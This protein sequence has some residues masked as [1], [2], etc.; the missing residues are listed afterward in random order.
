MKVVQYAI[1]T[2][3][4]VVI[5]LSLAIYA[6]HEPSLYWGISSLTKLETIYPTEIYIQESTFHVI[7]WVYSSLG[8]LIAHG[9][10]M[11]KTNRI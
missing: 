5:G 8:W 2:L 1:Y 4:F 9:W 10:W 11:I 3:L 6:V 7:A